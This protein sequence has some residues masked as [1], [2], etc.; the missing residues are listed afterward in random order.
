[1][2]VPLTSTS[3]LLRVLVADDEGPALRRLRAMLERHPHVEVVG[4][5]EDG[6]G[7]VRLAASLAPDVVFLD[8][9]MP[10][11][12]GIATARALRALGGAA[13]LIVFATAYESFAV[14]AFDVDAIDYL[15]KP[16]EQRRVHAAVERVRARLAGRRAGEPS[17]R[18]PMPDALRFGRAS[19]DFVARRAECSG[20]PVTL[21]PR[22]LE[23]LAA[24]A[25]AN[26]APV[27]RAELLARV[28]GYGH[29]VVS[30]TLDTHVLS[31]RQKLEVD[32]AE[33]RHILTERGFGYRLVLD[34]GCPLGERR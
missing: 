13:P 26:G 16:Y 21:R 33:P 20:T 24:L 4:T 34:E 3:K 25:A 28:W 19:I 30:R 23:L 1:M 9:G 15:L 8:I 2:S 5:A 29:D 32:P 6:Q 17:A 18:P 11:L 7:A 27:S 14:A 10:G 31:L 12:D 22:E